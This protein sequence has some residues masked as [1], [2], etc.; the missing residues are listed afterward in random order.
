MQLAIISTSDRLVAHPHPL[1]SAENSI[2]NP[3]PLDPALFTKTL[4]PPLTTTGLASGTRI[5]AW[6]LGVLQA[7]NPRQKLLTLAIWILEEHELQFV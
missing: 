4:G 6:L 2:R 5:K 7:A 1:C 3:K